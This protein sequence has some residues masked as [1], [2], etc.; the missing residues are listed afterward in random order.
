[1]SFI[2]R[3]F[4]VKLFWKFNKCL[5]FLDL[6]TNTASPQYI[7]KFNF[8]Y[9]LNNF[10][11]R[12]TARSDKRKTVFAWNKCL[13]LNRVVSWGRSTKDVPDQISPPGLSLDCVK[14]ALLNFSGVQT[15]SLNRN[16]FK[17]SKFLLIYCDVTKQT[18]RWYWL[19]TITPESHVNDLF[20]NSG[21]K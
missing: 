13:Y 20:E 5:L 18:L 10:V 4:L 3:N 8:I 19:S 17:I 15:F 12:S 7:T 14:L 11:T 6:I 9:L 21:G 2:E 1:M 16:L